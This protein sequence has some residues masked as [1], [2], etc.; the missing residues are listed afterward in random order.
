MHASSD[1]VGC[2]TRK[3][4]GIASVCSVYVRTLCECSDAELDSDQF[5]HVETAIVRVLL[6]LDSDRFRRLA[7][8]A[9]IRLLCGCVVTLMQ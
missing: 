3:D 6:K 8:T 5:R 4:R 7:G 1:I 2:V 9:V